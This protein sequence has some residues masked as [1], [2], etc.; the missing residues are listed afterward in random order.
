[1]IKS[2]AAL[3]AQ[4]YAEYRKQN[5]LALVELGVNRHSPLQQLEDAL[6]T[7]APDGLQSARNTVAMWIVN[8]RM[9]VDEPL[10]KTQQSQQSGPIN[11]AEMQRLSEAIERETTKTRKGSVR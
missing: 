11:Y 6:T 3:A 4:A 1:M 10:P 5:Y 2:I 9:G 8:R 7:L